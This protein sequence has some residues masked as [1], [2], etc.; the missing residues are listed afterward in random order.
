M[1]LMRLALVIAAAFLLPLAPLPQASAQAV[2]TMHL[3]S[4][5]KGDTVLDLGAP[6]AAGTP[7]S[8]SGETDGADLLSLDVTEQDDTFSFILAVAGLKGEFGSTSTIDFSWRDVEYYALTQYQ[9]SQL[10]SFSQSVLL[11]TG[12]DGVE[13]AGTLN[14]TADAEKGTLTSIVPKVYLLDGQKR[15]PS[16]GDALTEIKVTAE[17]GFRINIM[18]E[19]PTSVH[20]EM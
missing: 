11:R 6:G 14:L 15:T 9:N 8:V 2:G 20:D 1:R 5:E 12:E 19:R 7:F 3:L 4:D 16:L 17:A 18:G 13:R 10:G